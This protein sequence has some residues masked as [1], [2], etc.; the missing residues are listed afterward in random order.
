MFAGSFDPVM[1]T[2][3]FYCHIAAE[4]WKRRMQGL[5]LSAYSR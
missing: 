3:A 1:V 4:M 5:R 2:R